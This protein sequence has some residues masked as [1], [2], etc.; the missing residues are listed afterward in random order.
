MDQGVAPFDGS[1]AGAAQKIDCAVIVKPLFPVFGFPGRNR[2]R[3]TTLVAR[4][5]HRLL[6]S[7]QTAAR[8]TQKSRLAEQLGK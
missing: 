6:P 5:R 3:Q 4:D 1:H 8:K 7:P 2:R